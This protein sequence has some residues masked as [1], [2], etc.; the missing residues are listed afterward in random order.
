MPEIETR[1]N[2]TLLP[3]TDIHNCFGCSPRNSSGMHMKFYMNENG[4]SVL[5]WYSVPEHLCGW[6]DIVHG[7]IVS[8]ML[9]EAMGWACISLLRKLLFSK[10]IAVDFI[11][12]VL[13]GREITV[14]GN[15]L[16]INSER[17]AVMQGFIYDE[18]NEVCAKSSSVV[19]LFTLESVRKMGLMDEE[20]LDYF[21]QSMKAI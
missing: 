19:S 7:G 13:I 20:M 8:T 1:E 15:V 12:P 9:D 14:V 10:S 6:G 21:E 16:E 3:N 5:S 2:C 4:D 18:N 11:K 17:E